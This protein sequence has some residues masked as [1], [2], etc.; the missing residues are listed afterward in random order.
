MALKKITDALKE[1]QLHN[2]EVQQQTIVDRSE[3]QATKLAR[4]K[5]AR[6]D[7]AYFVEY[8]FPHFAKW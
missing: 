8:Y 1:W 4:I 7:Y 5:R 2:E 6:K 3:S